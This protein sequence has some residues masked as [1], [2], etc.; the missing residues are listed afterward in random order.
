M[1]SDFRKC[2]M[3]DLLGELER[4]IAQAYDIEK[5]FEIIDELRR[6]D[7]VELELRR[8]NDIR[9]MTLSL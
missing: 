8:K 5:G 9:N 3:S 7:D 1:L 6:R 2:T 4:I